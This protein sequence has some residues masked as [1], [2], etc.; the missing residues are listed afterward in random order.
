[1]KI[2]PLFICSL[3]LSSV[4]KA[5]ITDSIPITGS[6]KLRDSTILHSSTPLVSDTG[7]TEPPRNK[8][9][10]LLDDDTLY[11]FKYHWFTPASRVVLA[12]LT[13]WALD[14]YI[15]KFDWARVGPKDWKNNFKKGPEWDVD[16]FGIN[17]IGHPHSGNY[18][19]NIAR[20][21][22]YSFWGSLPFAI[23][24]SLLWEFF[25]ENTRPSYNDMINTP[26]SGMFLGEV[27][28][29]ISSNILDDRKTGRR[30][31]WRELLAGLIDPPR[32]MNR[33]T[34][35][36]LSRIT[37]KQVYQQEP[38]NVTLSMGVH[39]VND[40]LGMDN[41]FGTGQSNAMLNLQLDYG[42]PFETRRRK[43][44]DVFRLRIELG[45]GKDKRLLDHVNGYGLLKGWNLKENR[46]LGGL[47][48]HYD[49]WDNNIFQVASIGYGGGLI[50]KIHLT[51]RSDMYSNIH[52]AVVPLAGNNT[53]YGPDTSEFRHYNFGGGLQWKIEET[54][55]IGDRAT[56][57]FTGFYYWIHTYNGL[58][59]NSLV[60]ILK[61]T[62][63][64]RLFRNM[65]LGFEHHIYHNDR[66]LAN[67]NTL[68]L[69]RTE[70][71][72]FLQFFLEDRQRTG[73]YH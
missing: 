43:P 57:G 54:I 5:Q 7:K 18:Y 1:M 27:F 62:I 42:D 38:L 19:F 70:Q 61:P 8:Y 3:A 46:L 52:L 23:E 20:S 30:R 33:L 71:K 10:D 6:N 4:L 59:G 39:K 32:A 69:T 65:R 12:D 55:N 31:V 29:R 21:N 45:Y 64:V 49:Y 22:G 68:H 14:R 44:F 15:F 53:Q 35:G 25:A 48:Q 2:A 34:Q 56:V 13:N 24:G 67:N 66:F 9:G 73:K 16:G 47:F 26:I 51:S 36:K 63:T 17:F 41:K 11:N 58:P 28:Y 60:G 50:S 37:P 72:F 40:K